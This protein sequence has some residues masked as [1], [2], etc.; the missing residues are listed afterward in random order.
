M[1]D[2]TGFNLQKLN[3]SRWYAHVINRQTLQ[4]DRFHSVMLFGLGGQIE[5]TGLTPAPLYASPHFWCITRSL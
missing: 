1:L 2:F 5:P 3:D 4:Q